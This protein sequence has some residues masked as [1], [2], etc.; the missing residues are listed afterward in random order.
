MSTLWKNII[1]S[2]DTSLCSAIEKM[3][4]TGQQSLIVSNKNYDLLGTVSDGD[5]RKALVNEKSMKDHIAEIMNASPTTITKDASR[6]EII[7]IFSRHHFKIIPIIDG[8]KL[9]GCS[10]IDDY[11]GDNII[12]VPMII[13]AG[14]FGKRLGELTKTIPKPMLEVNGKPII[15]HIV[16]RAIAYGIST[17]YITVH[18]LADSIVNY[19]GDGTD[20]GVAIHYIY[21]DTPLGTAGGIQKV[22][23][24]NGPIIVSNADIM[25]NIN[26]K[27]LVQHHLS[28]DATATMAV[29]DMAMYNPFGVVLTDGINI[30]GF[31]EK[32]VW[33]T[34]IN[35][36][37]YVLETDVGN[38]IGPNEKINMPDLFTRARSFSKKTVIYQFDD[39]WSDIGNLDSY[40]KLKD[41]ILSNS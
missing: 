32:P 12:S 11:V 3:N 19:F 31:D 8:K 24:I 21:E 20:L 13:M 29:Y 9:I 23:A 38:L 14:G 28:N 33:R 40:E 26:Y 4:Q 27:K 1:I 25:S 34:K 7:D 6:S 15:R 35:A 5:I 10:Y 2:P 17:F 36:G 16:D 41:N 37:I 30:S 39:Q 18:Y 22:P